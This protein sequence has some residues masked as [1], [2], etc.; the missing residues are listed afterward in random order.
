MLF[1]FDGYTAFIFSHSLI[2]V[3][4]LFLLQFAISNNNKGMYYIAGAF[5]LVTVAGVTTAMTMN[6]REYPML[7]FVSGAFAVSSSFAMGLGLLFFSNLKTHLYKS[8]ALVVATLWIC[9]IAL[10]Y[11]LHTTRPE[12]WLTFALSKVVLF[13]MGIFFAA[14]MYHMER[15]P[16]A[17]V[18]AIAMVLLCGIHIFRVSLYFLD[19]PNRII[20]TN[21]A[22]HI[23]WLHLT[24]ALVLCKLCFDRSNVT[25][26]HL[27]DT[28][29]LTQLH[30]RRSLE[31]EFK[32]RSNKYGSVLILDIDHFKSLN[33]KYGHTVGDAALT[34]VAK[35]I[36]GSVR[37]DDFVARYGGEEFVVLLENC[38]IEQA[39]IVAEKIRRA[40]ASNV[41]ESDGVAITQTISGGIYTM[42][43]AEQELNDV[44]D[45][46]DTALYNAKETG[47]NRIVSY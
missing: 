42:E 30:N 35:L 41:F 4:S 5:A 27:V 15:M 2:F 28:D 36:E 19:D 25:I 37:Q 43:N 1:Q 9:T 38:S 8:E 23:T 3:C 11:N 22:F 16:S 44:I 7:T 46:A 26:K 39:S 18:L 10:M 6:D 14:Y 17:I 29:P 40:V 21:I 45:Q 32:L 13:G 12:M 31:K 34:H 20:K 33:D 47:R 24:L